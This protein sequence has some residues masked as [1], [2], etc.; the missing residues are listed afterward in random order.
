MNFLNGIFLPKIQLNFK[1]PK[2]I[3]KIIFHHFS[4]RSAPT[5]HP[6]RPQLGHELGVPA[7]GGVDQVRRRQLVPALH[8]FRH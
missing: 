1:I 6:A 3:I 7:Q 2:K 5:T 8:P 4:V